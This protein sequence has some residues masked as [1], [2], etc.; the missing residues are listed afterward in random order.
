MGGGDGSGAGITHHT[1]PAPALFAQAHPAFGMCLRTLCHS[2][3]VKFPPLPEKNAIRPNYFQKNVE[4]SILMAIFHVPLEKDV[5]FVVGLSANESFHTTALSLISHSKLG[6]FS[7]SRRDFG[8]GSLHRC[9]PVRSLL[10]KG[11]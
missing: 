4:Y 3:G 5:E 7:S 8:Y 2:H 1:T 9:S 10:K 11:T 6:Y